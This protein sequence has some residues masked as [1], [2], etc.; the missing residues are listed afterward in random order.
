LNQLG[1]GK[2][3][4]LIVD[5][6]IVISHFLVQEAIIEQDDVTNKHGFEGIVKVRNELEIVQR[7]KCN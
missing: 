4:V 5:V 7:H 1:N 3:I 6:E 2:P